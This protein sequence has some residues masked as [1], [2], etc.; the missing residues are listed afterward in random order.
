MNKLWVIIQREYLSRVKKKSFLITTILVPLL[1]VGFYALMFWLMFANTGG[2]KRIA[3]VDE[4]GYFTNKLANKKDGSITFSYPKTSFEDLK[5][6][7]KEEGFEGIVYIPEE[8]NI[9]KV[10]DNIKYYSTKQIGPGPKD[11]IMDELRD[12]VKSLRMEQLDIDSDLLSNL[13]VSMDMPELGVS[14]DEKAQKTASEVL[15]I[16]GVVMGMILYFVL[17]LFGTMVM[18]GVKEEKTNRVVEVIMSSVK[19]FELMFGKIIGISLVGVTQFLIW[20]LLF[21]IANLFLR[22]VMISQLNFDPAS[23]GGAESTVEPSDLEG[24]ERVMAELFSINIWRILGFFIFYFLGGYFIYASLFSA[25]GSIVEDDNESQQLVFPV[26]MPI[27]I[28]IAIVVSVIN[29]PNNTIATIAS[30]FPLTSPIV[31]M[32]RIPFDPPL[33]QILLSMF[34]LILG[35]L[36]FIWLSAKI[37]RTGI[38]MYGKKINFKEITKWLRYS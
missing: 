16:L 10:N 1:I 20:T 35:V 12:R 29:D 3:V 14:G 26:M 38:L 32:A 33:W 8:L 13:D 2:T 11:Y 17:I 36:F 22:P 19:P 28:S 5:S 6:N 27:I 24:M 4:S 23:I 9:F 7:F 34:F 15:S 21:G 30:M 18:R 37:Y 31:M 25:V